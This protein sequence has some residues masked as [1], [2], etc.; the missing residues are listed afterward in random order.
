MA[1]S[2]T[3]DQYALLVWS[4]QTRRLRSSLSRVM[5]GD[6]LDQMF[7]S[8]SKTGVEDPS[9]VAC[10]PSKASKNG[11][12]SLNVMSSLVTHGKNKSL[13]P[14]GIEGDRLDEDAPGI[15]SSASSVRRSVTLKDISS[16]ISSTTSKCLE[17]QMWH[18][19]SS[20]ASRGMFHAHRVEHSHSFTNP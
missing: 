10:D 13:K 17:A 6:S 7:R 20:A 16:I 11:R 15:S 8:S 5:R 12:G 2:L 18:Q 14:K 4:S 9:V 3:T 1:H 19:N